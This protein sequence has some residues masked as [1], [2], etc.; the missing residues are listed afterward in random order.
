[1]R[2]FVEKL[3][4]LAKY[5]IL[6]TVVK[7]RKNMGI[8]NI[9]KKKKSPK[10][11]LKQYTEQHKTIKNT[12][13]NI[14]FLLGSLQDLKV[15]IPS[16]LLKQ[17]EELEKFVEE[18]KKAKELYEMMVQLGDTNGPLAEDVD[19]VLSQENVAKHISEMKGLNQ[20]LTNIQDSYFGSG[21]FGG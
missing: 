7:G 19:S 1:M 6:Y 10:D 14:S 3:T 18:Y 9:F 15:E 2:L 11:L 13:L 12:M 16:E 4:N 20:E 5:G 21:A 17:Y 8:L